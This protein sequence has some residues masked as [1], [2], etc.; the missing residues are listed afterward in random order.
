MEI[1]RSI[2]LLALISLFVAAAAGQQSAWEFFGSETISASIALRGDREAGFAS[3]TRLG[4]ESL[5][6]SGPGFRAE[7]SL[8]WSLGGESSLA[9]AF[10][11]GL[12]SAPS[13]AELPPGADLHRTIALDQAWARFSLGALDAKFG[14]IPLSWGSGYAFNPLGL[15]TPPTFPGMESDTA[16]GRFG[17]TASLSLLSFLSLEAYVL[18]ESRLRSPV[19]SIGEVELRAFPFGLRAVARLEEI[20]FA[21][22][23]G[24][25]R[26]SIDADPEW[27]AGADAT[28]F[29]GPVT[30]YAEAAARVL[31]AD[32]DTFRALDP[33]R[34][35]DACAGLSFLMPILETTLRAEGAWLGRGS[36]DSAAYDRASLIAGTRATLGKAY[37]LA[38]AE[39]ET[40][41]RFKAGAGALWN[42]FDA[43][44][45]WLARATWCPIPS[46]ELGID[47]ILYAGDASSEFG[48]TL[49]TGPGRSWDPFV[50]SLAIS[51]KASF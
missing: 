46:L 3:I 35:I 43:S 9:R 33:A 26:M 32:G 37:A 36:E 34:D 24:R 5:P 23:F 44:A 38:L 47:C 30:L 14:L 15:A 39:K 20:D 21:F 8:S 7:G 40:D 13:R 18:A 27:F 22:A 45:A 19:P 4:L 42:L 6:A 28:G 41:D 25:S 50:P 11:A 51:A 49:P 12:A 1:G 29:L 31:V 17:A 10:A 2:S 48:G 16:E